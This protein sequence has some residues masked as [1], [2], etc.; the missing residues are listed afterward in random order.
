MVLIEGYEAWAMIP[1]V[2]SFIL[3]ITFLA[4]TFEENHSTF[5][6]K[7]SKIQYEIEI[8]DDNAWKEL[9]PNYDILKK[10][11]KNKKIYRI[12]GDYLSQRRISLYITDDFIRQRMLNTITETLIRFMPK[13]MMEERI[14]KYGIK[15]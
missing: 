1:T 5:L 7:P 9:G 12:E 15:L 8:T 10:L 3:F 13:G 14:V 11:Y 4:I 2:I 6:N